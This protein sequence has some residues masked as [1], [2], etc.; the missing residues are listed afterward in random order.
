[1][2]RLPLMACTIVHTP[3]R[4]AFCWL[5]IQAERMSRP[6]FGY[7]PWYMTPARSEAP[8]AGPDKRSPERRGGCSGLQGNGKKSLL[9]AE[10]GPDPSVPQPRR[11]AKAQNFPDACF[12]GLQLQGWAH[13]RR[14]RAGVGVM[15]SRAV[16]AQGRS[17]SGR[18]TAP[19]RLAEWEGVVLSDPGKPGPTLGG[20]GPDSPDLSR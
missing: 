15:P 19:L 13:T 10:L 6:E 20:S 14:L 3:P 11:E 9:L 17:V 8:G 5:P 4:V 16:C 2:G 18:H 7:N 1:V 12:P